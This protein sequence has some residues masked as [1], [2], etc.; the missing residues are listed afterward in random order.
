VISNAGVQS[1]SVT[2]QAD[3]GGAPAAQSDFRKLFTDM[4]RRI[5][6]SDVYNSEATARAKAEH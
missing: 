2:V 4:T 6:V 5:K 1:A 3:G